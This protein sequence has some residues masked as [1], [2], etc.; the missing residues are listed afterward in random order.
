MAKK[1]TI[2]GAL[3]VFAYVVLGGILW[4]GYRHLQ[5]PISDLTA[6]GAPDKGLLSAITFSYGVF[7]IIF[8]ASAYV[9]IKQFAPKISRV[10]MLLF[11]VMHLVSI[12][13]GLFP[14]DLPGAPVTFE[15]IMH[16]VITALIIPLTILAPLLTGLGLRKVNGLERYGMY[17]ILTGIL[18]F[19]A[20]GSAAI[21][22]P[23]N[24]RISGWWSGSISAC[25]SFG[26]WLHRLSFSP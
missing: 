5:Q 21:F 10:G 12:T 4:E 22:L 6:Q 18:I 9:F 16:L 11:L 13:Y 26:C 19:L 17:S 20:G 24:G 14:Q 23:I 1:L 7:S 25:C 8:A 3:S 2:F 15:G